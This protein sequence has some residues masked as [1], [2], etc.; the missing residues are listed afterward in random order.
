MQNH[1]QTQ[2]IVQGG[3]L[4][5]FDTAIDDKQISATIELPFKKFA[6]QPAK[7]A[8]ARRATASQP[9]LCRL[10]GIPNA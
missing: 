10:S 1:T 2:V 4:L 7:A 9:L 3:V 8:F 6:R 5:S